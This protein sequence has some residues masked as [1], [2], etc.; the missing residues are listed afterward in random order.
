MNIDNL[1]LLSRSS[2][3]EE[4]ATQ[5]IPTGNDSI[6]FLDALTGKIKQ[7]QEPQVDP[8]S[9][10]NL[11]INSPDY[12]NELHEIASFANRV[13]EIT[14]FS[15]LFGKELPQGNK[16][17]KEIELENILG[18]LENVLDTI[19]EQI[20]EENKL[21]VK[22]DVLIED[23]KAI[24][25]AIPEKIELSKKL[26]SI[27]DRL[28]ALKQQN[29]TDKFEPDRL[30]SPLSKKQQAK[31]I[32]AEE[33]GGKDSYQIFESD[34]LKHLDEIEDDIQQIKDFVS[35][36]DNEDSKDYDLNKEIETITKG[37]GQK[38]GY[39]VIE[40]D[41]LKYLDKIEGDIQQIKDFVL[42]NDNDVSKGNDLN[43]KIETIAKDIGD[44]KS[45]FLRV[46]VHKPSGEANIESQVTSLRGILREP[47]TLEKG[48]VIKPGLENL[49]QQENKPNQDNVD[50]ILLAKQTDRGNILDVGGL[51]LTTE[52]VVPKFAIDIANLNRAVMIE[53]KA[54]IP[55]MTKHFAHPEWNKEM[56]ERVVWMHKQ[57][58]PSAELRLNPGHLGPVKIKIDISQEQVTVA[59]TAQ[60]AAVKEA[61]DAALPKLREMFSAHQLNLSD[62]SVAQE[63]AGQRQ[64][65]NSGQMEGHTGKGSNKEANEIAN[66]QQS[67]DNMDI[68]DEIEAGRAI[69]S[70]GVLSIFA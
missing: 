60:H 20:P 68:A 34:Q 21:S 55:P 19:E 10:D 63:D 56:G 65:R 2:S 61:L 11:A 1:N 22:L 48:L 67:E 6:S 41:Q 62:V 39:Q 32:V 29:L 51:E 13:E 17:D 40:G 58:I 24:K 59:F 45:I 69:A 70:N 53:N 5:Q 25:I 31:E 37:I 46:G 7:L 30:V 8:S 64:S 33:I 50:S 47:A 15:A 26:S 27:V 66:S 12:S 14:D 44:I 57:E 43:K 23:I 35:I 4:G 38:S 49:F 3:A 9:I 18:T 42:I 54:E 28:E 52:R 36:N 16:V